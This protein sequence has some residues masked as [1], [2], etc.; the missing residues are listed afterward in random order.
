MIK[1]SI[2]ATGSIAH[3]MADTIRQLEGLELYAVASRTHAK[4]EAFRDE[5]GFEVAYGNYKELAA[6]PLSDIIYVAT[7][8]SSHYTAT[9]MLLENNHHV[10]CEKPLTVNANQ[11]MELYKLAKER[12]VLLV[13][14]T[15]I[16]Y[17]PFI[18]MVKKAAL[19]H[20]LGD[21]KFVVSTLGISKLD[22]QR[23]VDPE[24]AGGA[25]L[26]LGIYPINNAVIFADSKLTKIESSMTP[27]ETG[28]DESNTIVLTFENGVIGL[29][30][31]SMNGILNPKT[32][33]SYEKGRIELDNIPNPSS[34]SIYDEM[35]ELIETIAV[36]QQ[37]SGYEYQ[38]LEMIETINKG[39]LEMPSFSMAESL[40]IL[41]IMDTIRAQWNLVYPFELN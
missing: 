16:R 38:V 5:Y 39:E 3:E 10:L 19:H 26:D 13:D 7:P 30:A 8:H 15:W 4:A 29:L 32:Q 23:M 35:Q 31:S 12:G 2:L 27:Y 40:E 6:D 33:L 41:E 21:L 1:F 24:L 25:L 34:F 14:A 37:I 22:D 11:A 20:H 9:K 17:M 18:S 36:P 28:V